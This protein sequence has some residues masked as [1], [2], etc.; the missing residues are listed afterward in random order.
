MSDC[1]ALGSG[2]GNAGPTAATTPQ[3]PRAHGRSHGPGNTNHPQ[4]GDLGL[5]GGAG[6]EIEL[7]R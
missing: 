6:D 3:R 2:A 5:R 7:A 1:D 4:V